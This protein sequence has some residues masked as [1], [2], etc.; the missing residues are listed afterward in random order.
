MKQTILMWGMLTLVLGGSQNV[1]AQ[2]D[3]V[4]FSDVSDGN[5]LADWVDIGYGASSGDIDNDGDSD[6]YVS[7]FTTPNRLGLNTSGI[8]SD[9]AG[10]AGVEDPL[11]T[12]Y[13]VTFGDINNDGY[14]DIYVV[15]VYDPLAPPEDSR[16]RLY[17]N[18]RDR[19]FTDIAQVAGVDW[20]YG[21]DVNFLDYNRDGLLDIYVTAVDYLSGGD[22]PDKLY[23]NNGNNIFTDIAPSIGITTTGRQGTTFDYD[24]DGDSDLFV[25]PSHLY[26]NDGGTFVDVTSQANLSSAEGFDVAVGDYNNDGNLDLYVCGVG[27]DALY[28]N[29]GNGTFSD[30]SSMA[31]ITD[32]GYSWD[33]AF[34]DFNN[35]GYLD[36]FVRNIFNQNAVLYRNNQDG[37][38]TDIASQAGITIPHAQGEGIA[39]FDRDSDGD[40]DI[41]LAMDSFDGTKSKLF[42]NN[43][44]T[45]Y[46]FTLNLKGTL[47]NKAAIGA[48]VKLVAGGLTQTRE[49]GSADGQESLPVEFGL[50]THQTVDEIEIKWPSGIVQRLSGVPVNQAVTVVESRPSR[51]RGG[52]EQV[53]P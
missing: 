41:F 36:I 7:N 4:T 23:R 26:R 22:L 8:F 37:T 29:N 21:R 14:L 19:T 45:N 51:R 3:V 13:G 10:S 28:K 15:N 1:F 16:N 42:A 27:P 53:A 20:P 35:D 49:V 9:I 50:G 2:V 5:G 11:G 44:N 17:L 52:K 32:A 6:L 43:G 31:G 38:L 12:G 24:N 46:W 39:V 47:S 40:M 34:A 25:L 48:R 30:V 18:N 33:C